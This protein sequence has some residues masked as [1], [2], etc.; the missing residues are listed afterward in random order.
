MQL[1][2]RFNLKSVRYV[3]LIV[4]SLITNLSIAFGLFSLGVPESI[5]FAV[6][7]AV[8]YMLNFSG[9]RWF[10]FVSTEVPLITQFIQFAIT[11]GTF[12]IL[13]YLSLLS[14]SALEFSNYY[15]RVLLVLG[16]SF[17]IK[18][19]VYGKFVFGNPKPSRS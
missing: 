16:T 17:V 12:R 4:V 5:S 14:L 15:A 2:R 19:F 8:T 7:L 18:F 13:E 1:N 9:C 11:N 6:A 3:I 10:V